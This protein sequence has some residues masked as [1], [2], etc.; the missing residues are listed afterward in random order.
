M[1]F[2]VLQDVR[3]TRNKIQHLVTRHYNCKQ[4]K[5]KGIDTCVDCGHRLPN[6]D[7]KGNF[8]CW[9]VDLSSMN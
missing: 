2:S 5:Q 6:R 1:K 8:P 7:W 4:R 9:V 3:D